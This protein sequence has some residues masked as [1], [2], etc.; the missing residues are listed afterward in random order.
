M[1]FLSENIPS[2]FIPKR[3]ETKYTENS[4]FTTIGIAQLSKILPMDKIQFFL[5]FSSLLEN[6]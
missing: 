6:V 3:K 1:K 4:L 5:Y 2:I